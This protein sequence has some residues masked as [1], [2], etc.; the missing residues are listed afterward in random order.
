M[1][2]DVAAVPADAPHPHEALQFINFLMDAQVAAT[3]NNTI[4][5]PNGNA[6][7]QS[8]LRPELRNAEVFPDAKRAARLFAELP[9]SD[10]YLRL[11]TRVWTRFRTGQ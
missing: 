4:G 9:K 10:D 2:F 11:R 7:S 3:N 5:F 1:W 8:A 6:A